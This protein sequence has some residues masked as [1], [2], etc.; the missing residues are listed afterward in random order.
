M[1]ERYH[2][3]GIGGSGMSG[4]A[5]LLRAEGHEVR[6]SDLKE[7]ETTQALEDAGIRVA[8]GHGSENLAGATRVVYTAAVKEDNPELREAQR[9]GIPAVTRAELL[10]E[11]MGG[12]RGVAVAGTHGKTTVTGM[13]ASALISAGAD[14]TVLV[15]GDWAGIGGNVR[16]GKGRHFIAESCEAFGSFLELNPDVAIVT[17]IE[18]DHL[19]HYGSLEGVEAGFRQFLEQLRP[20]GYAIGCRDDDRVRRLLT[21]LDRRA[22]TYGLEDGAD[23]LAVDLRIDQ[24]HPTFTVVRYG[25]PVGEVRLGI[26]GRH[27]V[28]N[29]LSVIALTMEEGLDLEAAARGL[30]RFTGVRRRFEVLGEVDDILVLDDY[31]HHPTEIRATLSAGRRSLG[32]YTTVVFQPHLYSRTQLLMDE[33][34]RSF[35]D[36]NRVIVMDIYGAREQPVEGVTAEA[37]VKR[38]REIEPARQVEWI[39]GRVGVVNSLLRESRPGDV[40]FSMGAGDV[41]EIGEELVRALEQ[42]WLGESVRVAEAGETEDTLLEEKQ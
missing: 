4:L 19:E 9:L 15:G 14:P 31:A 26:P 12:K 2:F 13:A 33:F 39:P 36:A 6:G 16:L 21:R 5:R 42:R 22:I 27:N 32:R 38:M 7:S 3:I 17:N 8:Y 37:L 40:V 20:G 34:A 28:L 30:S 25:A 10:G 23:Y 41:R 18:A 35:E 29:A 24:L 11:V 1:T